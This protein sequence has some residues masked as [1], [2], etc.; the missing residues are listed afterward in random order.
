[1]E[2]IENHCIPTKLSD[3]NEKQK[4]ILFN[5]VDE[6]LVKAKNICY[7][8]TA[9][10]LKHRFNTETGIYVTSRMFKDA[11]L[12]KGYKSKQVSQENWCFNI[13]KILKGEKQ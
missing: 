7:T 13:S 5:W 3:L 4:N 10:G 11:M 9:Y 12:Q 2:I 1:M 8:R 6:R